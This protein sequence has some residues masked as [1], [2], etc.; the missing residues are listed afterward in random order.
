MPCRST[1]PMSVTEP[2]RLMPT[3]RIPISSRLGL[4]LKIVINPMHRVCLPSIVSAITPE[5]ASGSGQSLPARDVIWPKVSVTSVD[6][7]SSPSDLA[8]IGPH[9]S[10]LQ[11]EAAARLI[12]ERN[13]E[14]HMSD[15]RIAEP[16]ALL[17]IRKDALEPGA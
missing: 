12:L 14:R 17:D 16:I 13:S 10:S 2:G 9:E 8:P 3:G 6:D 11:P 15:D 7:A 5:G 1:M 4:G